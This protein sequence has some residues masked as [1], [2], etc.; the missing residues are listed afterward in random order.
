MFDRSLSYKIIRSTD[1]QEILARLKLLNVTSAHFTNGTY[2]FPPEKTVTTTLAGFKHVLD[3]VDSRLP[4][5]IAINSDASMMSLNKT[6]YEHQYKRADNVAKPL[7]EAFPQNRVIVMFYD[8]KTPNELYAFLSK[9]NITHTLHKWGY[10]TQPE[11]PKIEGAEYFQHVYGYPLVDDLKP[12]CWQETPSAEQ[13]NVEVADLR[14]VLI[15][16]DRKCLFQL[17]PSL[18]M[19]QGE[20]GQLKRLD[21]KS[22]ALGAYI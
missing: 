14:N 4:L 22:P 7:A 12:V 11:L 17:P 15:T 13:Q 6:G 2:A 3:H 19:Y 9:N 5:I 10:G 1:H 18:S 20:G 8:D 16:T 21:E